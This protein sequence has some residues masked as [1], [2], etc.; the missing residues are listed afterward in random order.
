MKRKENRQIDTHTYT[1]RDREQGRVKVAALSI[2]FIVCLQVPFCL[3][4]QRWRAE[5]CSR[6][7]KP[8]GFYKDGREGLEQS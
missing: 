1:D 8:K 4:E 5:T 2:K 7:E 3:A 6:L